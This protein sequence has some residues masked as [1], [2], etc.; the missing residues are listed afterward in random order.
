MDKSDLKHGETLD[1]ISSSLVKEAFE[2]GEEFSK[3]EITDLTQ[4]P[5][6]VVSKLIDRMVE[7]GEIKKKGL[8]RFVINKNH[9]FYLCIKVI[10]EKFESVLFNSIY[11]ITE[12][13]SMINTSGS[14]EESLI[15]IIDEILKNYKLVCIA[16]GVQMP[17][18]DGV[19]YKD[20]DAFNLKSYLEQQFQLPVIIEKDINIVCLGNIAVNQIQFLDDE[21][22]VCLHISKTSV[23][24][25]LIYKTEVLTGFQGM[26]GEIG[27]LYKGDENA[28]IQN[29]LN[30]INAMFNPKTV[31][32]YN[33]TG[34]TGI[35]TKLKQIENQNVFYASDYKDKYEKGFVYL[36][37]KRT[38]LFSW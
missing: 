13:K 31:I 6:Q 28:L 4:L 27:Q 32:I 38:A 17:V 36:M 1:I 12:R 11:S 23:Q 35:E 19:I 15:S 26:A 37:K 14:F 16:V 8:N 22:T 2:T 33:E 7:S 3:K 9:S 24:C 5:A 30:L 18:K 21:Y 20:G 29:I 10:P 25:G 34:D